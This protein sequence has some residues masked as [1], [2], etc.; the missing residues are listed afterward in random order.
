MGEK[1]K[2]IEL[3]SPELGR[4][5]VIAKSAASYKSKLRGC[6]DPTTFI[7]V[8]LYRGNSFHLV[9]EVQVL[10]DFPGIRLEFNRIS[11]A[12]YCIDVIKKTTAFEQANLELF[13]ILHQFLSRLDQG[14]SHVLLRPAFHE[15]ILLAEGLW[16]EDYAPSDAVFSARFGEYCGAV[17]PPPLLI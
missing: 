7:R 11:F 5:K 8:Q 13:T 10:S 16:D 4:I 2:L 9:T 15:A 1:D 12:A 6:L 3:F 14:E 17:I